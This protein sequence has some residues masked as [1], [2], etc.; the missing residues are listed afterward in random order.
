MYVVMIRHVWS[1]TRSFVDV[2]GAT[3][4]PAF[5]DT[6]LCHG[7]CIRHAASGAVLASFP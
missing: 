6:L 7:R 2:N 1:H 4:S 5:S 3:D